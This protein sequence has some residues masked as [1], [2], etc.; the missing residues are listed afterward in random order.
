MAPLES[1]LFPVFVILKDGLQD[2][3]GLS[4]VFNFRLHCAIRILDI[5][6]DFHMVVGILD[7]LI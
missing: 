1:S 5:L 7:M 4:S 3:Y 2:C 6:Y